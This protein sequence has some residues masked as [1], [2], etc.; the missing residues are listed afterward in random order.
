MPDATRLSVTRSEEEEDPEEQVEGGALRL[1]TRLSPRQPHATGDWFAGLLA[2]WLAGSS[3][4]ARSAWLAGWPVGGPMVGHC[5]SAA[6]AG[7]FSGSETVF[8]QQHKGVFD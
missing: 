1:M 5:L 7:C 3:H 4:W 8:S 6:I 2:C